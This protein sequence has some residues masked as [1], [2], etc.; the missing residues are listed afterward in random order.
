MLDER[1]S[2][3]VEDLERG[4]RARQEWRP[5]ELALEPGR[6][7][8]LAAA[9]PPGRRAI[10]HR[11]SPGARPDGSPA[12]P[13]VAWPVGAASLG[14]GWRPAAS[15][16]RS[17][18]GRRRGP[19]RDRHRLD[20]VLLEARLDRRL[21]LLDATHDALDLAPG[22]AGQQ[23]DQRPGAGGVAG[24][25]DAIE[26]A[27]R[28][29]PE[30]HRVER[31]DLAAERAGQPHLVDRVAPELVHQQ[32]RTG[33][34]RGLGELDRAHVVLGDDDPRAAIGRLVEDVAEGPTVRRRPAASARRPTPSIT[35]SAVMTPARN[36]SAI[37]LDDPASRRCR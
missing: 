34:E 31:V 32:P 9:A 11:S 13:S 6:A 27:V 36:S 22:R 1:E 29:E 3:L 4:Q 33:V 8:S 5:L 19:M 10:G 21:D 2:L 37:D 30:D 20:E 18:F 24:R 28:D 15:T 35:P 23:R 7:P 16:T 14:G 26:V 12:A 25:P 17:R